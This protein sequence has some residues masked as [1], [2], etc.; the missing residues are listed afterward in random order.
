MYRILS[1]TCTVKTDFKPTADHTR[2]FIKAMNVG[3]TYARELKH[4]REQCQQR[5]REIASQ[6][7]QV[8]LSGLTQTQSQSASKDRENDKDKNEDE[9]VEIPYT[10]PQAQQTQ[11]Q[12][13][14]DS[15]QSKGSKGSKTPSDAPHASPG[16]DNSQ[17]VSQSSSAY[18]TAAS[19]SQSPIKKKGSTSDEGDR[20][21]SRS[22]SSQSNSQ[23]QSQ[24]NRAT[25][26]N[27]TPPSEVFDDDH[28]VE[29]LLLGRDVRKFFTCNSMFFQGVVSSYKYPYYFVEYVFSVV[30]SVVIV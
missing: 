7:S 5:D 18:A 6:G 13:Q 29:P 19:Q 25:P 17:P 15:Q 26:S 1:D 9:I 11:P 14:E 28:G 24:G 8:S 4:W 20:G 16:G 21:R 23:S 30:F 12:A 22:H 27:P 10:G 2:E 3:R